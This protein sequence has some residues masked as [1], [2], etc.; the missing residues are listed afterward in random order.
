MGSTTA[1]ESSH[2]AKKSSAKVLLSKM[3]DDSNTTSSNSTSESTV[4]ETITVAVTEDVYELTLQYSGPSVS[5]YAQAAISET[6][7]I[8]AAIQESHAAIESAIEANIASVEES[9]A[10]SLANYSAAVTNAT[11]ELIEVVETE[12]AAVD[13]AIDAI[14][15]DTASG[16]NSV[17]KQLDTNLNQTLS[18][19]KLMVEN[20]LESE[21]AALEEMLAEITEL[22]LEN[23]AAATSSTTSTG[24]YKATNCSGCIES[25]SCG[26]CPIESICVEGDEYGPLYKFCSYWN[27]DLCSSTSSVES[28]VPVTE[29]YPLIPGGVSVRLSFV[30]FSYILI[31]VERVEWAKR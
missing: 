11:E 30:G 3:S 22:A 1:S 20:Q 15:E 2:K 26:W 29:T 6:A 4:T 12:A 17:N 24:C 25:S 10:E 9:F 5:D 31:G 28:V 19:E 13:E 21:Q 8:N 27:Y 14:A 18:V 7:Q 16:Y 23:A